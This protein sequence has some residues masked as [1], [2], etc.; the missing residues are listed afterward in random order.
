M[1]ITSWV[2]TAPVTQCYA[3]TDQE[4]TTRLGMEWEWVT[5]VSV[6]KEGDFT[7]SG[8]EEVDETEIFEGGENTLW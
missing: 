8:L 7:R 5:Q 2:E 3:N 4:D 6:L 1:Y